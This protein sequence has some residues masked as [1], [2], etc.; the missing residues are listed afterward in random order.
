MAHE[1]PATM[2][3][4]RRVMRHALKIESK[5]LARILTGEKLFEIRKNDRDFQVGDV[6]EFLPL[7]DKNIDVYDFCN[8]IPQYRITYIHTGLGMAVE[9]VAMSIEAIIKK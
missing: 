2:L 3:T 7:E 6:I 8:P 4:K 5:Y 9:Y 1:T